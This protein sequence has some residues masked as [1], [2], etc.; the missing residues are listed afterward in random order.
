MEFAEAMLLSRAQ[1]SVAQEEMG[2]SES[3]QNR[4]L[5]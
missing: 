2:S 3:K 5:R 1:L 4:T